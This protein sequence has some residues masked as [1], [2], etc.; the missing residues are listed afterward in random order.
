MF[1]PEN[2][3]ERQL[4]AA[5]DGTGDR[6]AFAKALL[7]ATVYIA[8]LGDFSNA[9]QDASGNFVLADDTP[10]NIMT[11]SYSDVDWIAIFT[12]P[13]RIHNATSKPHAASAENA[14]EL[15]S[16]YPGFGFVLNPR[17]DYGKEF[18]PDEISRMLSGSFEVDGPIELK[19]GATMLIG[20]P[21]DYP[22]AFVNK[23]RTVLETMADVDAAY[24]SLV[25]VEGAES[26]MIEMISQTDQTTLA[27]RLMAQAG[28]DV[29]AGRPLD[30]RVSPSVD[31]AITAATIEPF[32]QRASS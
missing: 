8:L 3:I 21:D 28:A 32:F 22:T 18:L 19:A 31:L 13:L 23:V 5:A 14:K 17:S 30:I 10:V 2:D 11:A 24:F 15:F 9:R 25:V 7:D 4:I 26:L 27:K 6:I 20:T 29:P 1:K 12:S 16:Q